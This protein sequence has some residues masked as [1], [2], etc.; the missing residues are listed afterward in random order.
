M[1][2]SPSP[3]KKLPFKRR[4]PPEV[5]LTYFSAPSIYP[6]LFYQILDRQIERPIVA[7]DGA[8]GESIRR[9]APGPEPGLP[10]GDLLMSALRR[11]NRCRV[12]PNGTGT[13]RVS[14]GESC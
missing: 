11:I 10:D 5:P 12:R 2:L 13:V 7:G 14:K 3:A 8:T 4:N 9:G 1:G 6:A